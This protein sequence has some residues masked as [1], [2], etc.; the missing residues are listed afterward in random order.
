MYDVG[1]NASIIEKNRW[2]KKKNNRRK[3]GKLNKY[4][5]V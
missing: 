3:K 4:V 5:Q 2:M 1:S